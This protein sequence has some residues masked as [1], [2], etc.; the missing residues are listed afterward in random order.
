MTA[1]VHHVGITASEIATSP[2]CAR[3]LEHLTIGAQVARDRDDLAMAET[4]EALVLEVVR[5]A[6]V[7]TDDVQAAAQKECDDQWQRE[8]AEMAHDDFMEGLR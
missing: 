3:Y 8:R 7:A 6:R 1:H 2:D 4:M 5:I